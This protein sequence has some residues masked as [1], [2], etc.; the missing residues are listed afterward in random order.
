VMVHGASHTARGRFFARPEAREQLRR[1][2]RHFG[3]D[4]RRVTRDLVAGLEARVV[5][6]GNRDRED[7]DRFACFRALTS[8]ACTASGCLS[9][10]QHEP[11]DLDL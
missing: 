1:R 3:G 11:R 10:E 2:I 8:M 5:F 9:A 4:R 6:C 7:E